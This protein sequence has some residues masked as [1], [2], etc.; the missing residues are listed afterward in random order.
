MGAEPYRDQV[1]TTTATVVRKL[2]EAGA[3]LVAK[4]STGALAM[5]DLWYAGMTRNP[6]TWSNDWDWDSAAREFRR[7]IELDPRYATARQWYA[8]LLAARGHLDDAIVEAHTALELD[9]A[10]VS[11]R[12]TVGWIYYYARRYEQ[13]QHH[14]TR[15]IAMNPVS[16]ESLR[17]LGLTFALQGNF[18]EAE[19][20][21]REALDLGSTQTYTAAT[22]GYV[23]GRAG[24]TAAAE[25]ILQDVTARAERDY[26]S[27]VAFATLH[28]G[29]GNWDAALDWAERC[30]DERRGWLA[31]LRVNPLLDPLQGQ[32]R[33]EALA[34]KMRL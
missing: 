13:A 6:W 3:L 5:G 15:A 11:I 25:A 19:R 34:E 18:A 17:V 14:V 32:P 1:R 22:L 26:V 28:L 20:A 8:F 23:L 7:A 4:L 9:P 10:S 21:L 31:Y 33:F 16:D 12:R 2:I 30:Y 24:Q 27:P 29:L